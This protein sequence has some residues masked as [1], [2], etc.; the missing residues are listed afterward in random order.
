[1][2]KL[3]AQA[4]IDRGL[5]II[6]HLCVCGG[7]NGKEAKSD[8]KARIAGQVQPRSKVPAV[9]GGEGLKQAGLRV[10]EGGTVELRVELR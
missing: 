8:V 5:T 7:D 4:K 2:V 1:M 9:G 10:K 3:L 6:L